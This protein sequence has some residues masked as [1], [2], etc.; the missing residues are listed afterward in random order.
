MRYALLALLALLAA[1]VPADAKLRLSGGPKA[2]DRLRRFVAG[3]RVLRERLADAARREEA[4]RAEARDG[5]LRD[6]VSD[7]PV[8]REQLIEQL[9]G[10]KLPPAPTCPTLRE[11]ASPEL[12]ADVPDAER[13]PDAVRRLVRPWMLLQQA[14]GSVA[15]ISPASEGDAILSVRLRGLD[16][17]PLILNVSPRLLGG[18]K[19]W[20]D[21]PLLLAAL[22]G[23]ERDALLED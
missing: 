22:Y 2:E 1:P 4:F 6:A 11:C 3:D 9:P 14:R 8:R 19:V 7:L 20:F 12:A 10:M 18:F 16:A 17:E 13:L 5:E 21:R 15:E 23:R